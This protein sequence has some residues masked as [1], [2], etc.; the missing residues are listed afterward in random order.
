MR[1]PAII[2]SILGIAA[3]AALFA[4][5]SCSGGG[6]AELP[7]GEPIAKV[8]AP[9]GKQWTEVIS[10][11]E[12]GYQIGNPQAKLHLVEYG[13]ISCPV[14]A[15]FSV[16]STP[17]LMAMVDSGQILFEFRPFLVHGLQDVPGFL[18]AQC[19][20]AES[21]FGLS[22]ALYANQETWLG[23]LRGITPE[24]GDAIQKMK[25][26]DATAA[27][28]A[29]FQLVDFVKTLGVSEDNAKK[30]LTDKAAFDKLQQS[31]QQTMSE[32]K[33]SGT[34]TFFI[35]DA[36]VEGITAWPQLKA[37][38]QEAGAR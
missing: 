25:P 24:E 6:D 37:K 10:K 18:L 34:P 2:A 15:Q 8:A 17:E 29:R 32:G 19:N 4:L 30:C 31:T 3:L 14:C 21:F 26:E 7:K 27:L 16:Q 5:G 35:N 28:A 9:A 12:K 11:T 38:L 23:R 13:A 36:K 22:E 1:L 33:V 20:G